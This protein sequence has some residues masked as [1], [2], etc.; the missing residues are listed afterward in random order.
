M[1]NEARA[2]ILQLAT[3]SVLFKLQYR[4]DPQA[5][6]HDCIQFPE[7]E[8]PTEYQDEIAAELI[9]RKKIAVRGPHGLGKTAL[10]AW[11]A[12]WGILTADD[13][14]VPTTASAW[15]Q[16]T[17][18][19]WP[20]IHK[21]AARLRWD[22]LDREPFSRDELLTLAL[23]LGPMR[24]AFAVASDNPDLI[25][26]A[27]A[28][29]I[30]Y[31][32]D[33]SKAVPNGTFDA[34]EGAFSGAGGDTGLEAYALAIS[35]P[36]APVGRFYDIHARKPGYEDWWAR[37]VTLDE[38]VKA[39]RI[40][41]EW[42]EA[43]LRQWGPTSAVFLNRVKGEFASSEADGVIALG[44]VE[45]ANRK[46]QEWAD[47]GKPMCHDE[48]GKL[49]PMDMAGVDV[50]RSGEDKTVFALRYGEILTELRA[51]SKY[52]TMR[53]TGLVA[54]LLGSKGGEAMVDV[55][56]IGA[57]V[58]DR[59]K[60]QGKP[61]RAFNAAAGAK[62]LKDKSGELGFINKRSAAWWSLREQLEAGEV[63]LPPD[64][65]LTGD[66]VAPHWK[67]QSGGK[68]KIESKDDIKKRIGRSTDYGDAVVMAFW[69]EP[70]GVFFA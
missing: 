36:G 61:A 3:P 35:T 28:K 7:G 24:E 20:E 39:G 31:I 54:G 66:L 5:F 19:L 62:R 13:V 67:E 32:F 12:L 49:K 2:E 25:E 9:V 52:D 17:K 45:E 8:A 33:E 57:G 51:Y 21:W 11:L 10:A 38:A 64:D 58:Y 50:A 29:R 22:K 46:W 37:H 56:G 70:K 30:L 23:K 63:M 55:I 59:L 4:H 44:W 53:T 42:A 18:F 48:D 69:R 34:A 40:S 1:T 6:I 43:R 26:G 65:M 60:E 16:L 15:R 27:H 47:A 68:I 41:A 14:K